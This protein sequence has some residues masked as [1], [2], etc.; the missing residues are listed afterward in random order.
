MGEPDLAMNTPSVFPDGRRV[1]VSQA[2]QGTTDVWLQDSTRTS[3]VTF[4]PAVEMYPVFSPDGTRLVFRSSRSGGGDLYEKLLSGGE[5]EKPIMSS[6]QLK[7]PSGWS[8]DGRYMIFMNQDP[9]TIQI[10]GFCPQQKRKQVRKQANR[11]CF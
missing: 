4:D 10:C 9:Q 5:A 1:A 3:R 11:P 6:D 2:V 7:T 8:S